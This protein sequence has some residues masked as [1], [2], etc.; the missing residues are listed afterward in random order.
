VFLS[1]RTVR[2]LAYEIVAKFLERCDLDL[3]HTSDPIVADR[4]G[5]DA[6]RAP[7]GDARR[8]EVSV[9]DLDGAICVAAKIA[10]EVGDLVRV[11]VL[12]DLLDAEP[13]AEPAV[14]LARWKSPG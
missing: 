5:K 12:L 2:Q 6:D 9:S 7:E 14:A 11:R 13:R 8:C 1:C 10:I 4:G 3:P